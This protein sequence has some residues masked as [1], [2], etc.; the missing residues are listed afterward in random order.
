MNGHL[1]DLSQID[2]D[3]EQ[4]HQHFLIWRN[5][6]VQ[7]KVFTIFGLPSQS[8]EAHLGEDA[9]ETEESQE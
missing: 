1:E 4:L 7:K 6:L 3:Q 9:I 2:D 5:L 8:G